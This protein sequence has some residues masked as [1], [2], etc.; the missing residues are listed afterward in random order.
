MLPSN[1]KKYDFIDALRGWAILGVIL[2]HS[3]RAVAPT[4]ATLQWGMNEG[5]RGVQLFYVVSALTLCMSWMARSAYETSPVRNFYIRRF[6]RIAPLFY[7]FILIYLLL[8]G[9]DPA[10]WSPNGIKWWF[11][12]MTAVFLHGFHPE[13]VNSVVPGGWTIAVEMS[14]Y[15]FFPALLLYIRSLKSCL[16]FFMISLM[17][18]GLNGLIVPHLFAYPENQQYLVQNFVTF[19][20]LGQ[21]PVFI[22]GI[23]CYLILGKSYPRKQIAIVGGSIFIVFLLLFCYPIAGLPHHLIAGGLFSVFALLLAHWPARLLVNRITTTIG[24]LSFGMYLTH[25]VILTYFS[26]LGFSAIFQK[27]NLASVLY[28]ICV[29]LAAAVVSSLFHKYIENPGIALGKR[30][31]E[32]LEVDGVKQ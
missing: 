11:V 13:T 1:I 25:F 31:I 8:N 12:P 15:L 26:R 18:Y 14:F 32:K 30:L 21:L 17:V 29:V 10:Y 27:S 7:I 9:L 20:F 22:G 5:A 4:N 16:I 23:G 3:S 28:F 19:N 2:V 6:F 24:K